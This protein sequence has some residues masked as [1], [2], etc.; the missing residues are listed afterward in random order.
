MQYFARHAL[1][2]GAGSEGMRFVSSF[3][4]RV[5]YPGLARAGHFRRRRLAGDLC[6][7][8]Y[9][10][11]LPEGYRSNDR[12]LDGNLVSADTLRAQLRLLKAH[13][14]IASPEDVLR[15][16]ESGAKLASR[17]VLLTCDDGLQNVLTDMLPI[18]REEDVACV[19]FVTGASA[20]DDVAMLW[21][22][23]LY[24]LL[25][26]APVG[27]LE[28][29]AMAVEITTAEPRRKLWW[30]WVNRLSRNDAQSRRGFLDTLRERAGLPANWRSAYESEGARQRFFLMNKDALRQLLEA[31]MAVG[32]H[33]MT[34]P[35]LAQASSEAAWCE[36]SKSREVLENAAG[37]SIWGLAYPFGDPAA[38]GVR[39]FE[40]AERAGYRCAFMNCGGGFRPFSSRF[41]I[42]RVHVTADMTLGEFEAHVSGFYEA[43]RQ[44]LGRQDSASCG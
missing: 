42:P 30:K 35:V 18:L 34:H 23:E 19:F 2:L 39:E 29:P 22:E 4:K 32:A 6:V 21:Y 7:V 14:R 43:F 41:A 38:A 1:E 33:T 8:T 28:L 26:A 31:G 15:S 27:R 20:G 16:L 37:T 11:V 44:R 5:V 12:V 36:I 25:M 9:H 13:Y 24:L 10:G 17:S 3:L 40:M